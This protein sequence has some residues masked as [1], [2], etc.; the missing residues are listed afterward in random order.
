LACPR[1]R[2]TNNGLSVEHAQGDLWLLFPAGRLDGGRFVYAL[3]GYRPS[4]VVTWLA[5][6]TLALSG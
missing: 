3:W 5:I 4:L 1:I 6:V 2:F